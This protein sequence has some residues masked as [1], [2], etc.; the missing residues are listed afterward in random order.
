[1]L[2]IALVCA[3]VLAPLVAL[4]IFS[5]LYVGD[6]ALFKE[7]PALS[8]MLSAIGRHGFEIKIAAA[9]IYGLSWAVTAA[10]L[11]RSFKQVGGN[12]AA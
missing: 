6:E 5:W 10:I 8:P 12:H 1:M 2:G 11:A 7:S 3:L 9:I 4:F